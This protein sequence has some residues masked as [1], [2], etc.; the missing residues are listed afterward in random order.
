MS[1]FVVVLTGAGISAESGVRTFRAADGLWENHHIEEVAT[2][3]GFAADPAL[4]HEFYNA[5]RRQLAAVRPNLAHRALA[6][7]EARHAGDFLLVTQN[8]DDLHERAG[9]RQLLHMHGRLLKMCCQGCGGVFAIGEDLSITTACPGC[10]AT[11]G[12]RPDVV[13][14][15][16]MPYHMER[17][18][19]ALARC[20]L[21]VSIGTSGGVYPAAGF[22]QQALAVGAECVE[23]N[24][25]PS[26]GGDYFTRACY[27][28]ASE[29]VPAFFA[30]LSAVSAK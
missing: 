13:W 7:F 25:Q 5:R 27:G 9:S 10:T 8:I 30:D 11:G 21:F 19:A 28:L 22:V 26:A 14:F 12:L 23:L 3:A 6:D 16:E 2:P 17:I 4:V 15:G 18:N 20:D 1:K 29:V 24:L